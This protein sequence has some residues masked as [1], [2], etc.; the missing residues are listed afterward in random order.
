[1]LTKDIPLTPT[2]SWEI[3]NQLGKDVA[4]SYTVTGRE[5]RW[6]FKFSIDNFSVKTS[7]IDTVV[8]SAVR[9]HYKKVRLKGLAGTIAAIREEDLDKVKGGDANGVSSEIRADGQT[10]SN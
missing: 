9:E 5:E 6:E 7:M 3:T 4:V 10:G 8:S 1:M 2:L